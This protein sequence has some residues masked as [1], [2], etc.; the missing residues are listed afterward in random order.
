MQAF[1]AIPFPVTVVSMDCIVSACLHCR[2]ENCENVSE[3]IPVKE[4]ENVDN[5]D[6]DW[7][8]LNICRMN[9]ANS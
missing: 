1:G 5:G 6:V 7:E 8:A 3:L 9:Y 2:G 4:A